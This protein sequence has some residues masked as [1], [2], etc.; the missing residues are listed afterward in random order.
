M[1]GA[2]ISA[3][4]SLLGGL[5]GKNSADATRQA[6][7][8]MA[9][10]NIALQREFAQNGI[11]WRV[12]DAKKA[13]IHPIYALGSGGAS[14]SPVSAAFSSD[15]SLPNALAS[16][17]QDIGRAVDKTRTAADRFGVR[18]ATALQLEGLKLDNDLKR[19]EIASKTAR[20]RADQVGPPMPASADAY[21][22]PGQSNS[23]LIKQKPLELA[24]SPANAPHAE[25][26]SHGDV[27]YARTVTGGYAP[28]PSKDAKDRNE[29]MMIPEMLWAWRNNIMPN[30]RDYYRKPPPF[31]PGPGREWRWSYS[32]QEYR[33]VVSP[34]RNSG[35]SGYKGNPNLW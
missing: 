23:G 31:D 6:Q 32:G 8:D 18:A 3:G 29:D 20:L 25:G 21:L 26:G 7:V 4:S 15:T 11:Q 1:L 17:G 2:L 24:P 9:N 27:G 16:A 5:L 35:P 22:I 34:K 14:F 19:T 28:V 12:E 33:S 10:Q 13:G 30:F